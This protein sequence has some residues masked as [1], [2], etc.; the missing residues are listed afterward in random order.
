MPLLKNGE[1]VADGWRT[2]ADEEIAPADEDVIVSL[3]RFQTEKDALKSRS[4]GLG[5]RVEPGEEVEAIADELGALGVIALSFP[6]FADGR[7]YSSARLLRTRYKYEGEIRAV[8]D[9]HRDQAFYMARCGFDAFEV[10][11]DAAL[12]GLANAL[13]D[14]SQAYQAGADARRPVWSRRADLADS[15]T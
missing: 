14:F 1:A 4:A 12:A 5:V 8:G 3:A 7:A 6:R 2:L 10:A 15:P 9:V 13:S 11:D